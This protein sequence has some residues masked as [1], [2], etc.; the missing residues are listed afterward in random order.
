[1]K[2]LIKNLK[3][4]HKETIRYWTEE[5]KTIDFSMDL[6]LSIARKSYMDGRIDASREAIKIIDDMIWR[7]L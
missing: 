7:E 4:R 1:M 2:D 5:K 6:E 3:K